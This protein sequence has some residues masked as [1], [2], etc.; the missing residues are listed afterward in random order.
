LAK[1]GKTLSD[2]GTSEEELSQL[3]IDGYFAMANMWLGFARN[4]NDDN[5]L[6]IGYCREYLAK[7]G[8]TFSD[9]GTN[10]EEL[11]QL[12]IDG[13]VAKAKMWLVFARERNNNNKLNIGYCRDYLA[14]A[15][16][17]LSDIGTSEEEISALLKSVAA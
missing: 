3:L 7:A 6:N 5:E 10:E 8:K 17:T 15:A 13:Y 12:L 1:A 4:R 9:I 11:S 14:K 2:I 16:K